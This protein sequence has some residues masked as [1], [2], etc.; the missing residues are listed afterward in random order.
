ML[1]DAVADFREGP[2]DLPARRAIDL[3]EDAAILTAIANDVGVEAIFRR[4]VETMMRTSDGV[5]NWYLK[6]IHALA[7]SGVVGTV[8]IEGLKWAEVDFPEDVVIAR[9]LTEGWMKG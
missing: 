5:R 8:S 4:Q 3:T 6:A 9:A 7:P 1:V 2:G